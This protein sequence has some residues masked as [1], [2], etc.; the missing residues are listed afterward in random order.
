VVLLDADDYI[1]LRGYVNVGANTVDIKT[2]TASTNLVLFR[3]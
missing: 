1:Q 3:L 2:G